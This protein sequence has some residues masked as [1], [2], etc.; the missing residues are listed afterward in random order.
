ME[1]YSNFLRDAM[2]VKPASKR[3]A[4]QKSS[5]TPDD[6]FRMN[7]NENPFGPSPIAIETLSKACKKCF[8]YPDWFSIELKKNIA[9]MYSL[10]I[11]NIVIGTGESSIICMLGEIF[12]N[13]GDE[14]IIGDPSYEGFRDVA[15]DYGAKP[16]IVPVTESLE[17][18]LDALLNAVTQKTKILVICNPN[19]PTGSYMDCA[20]L[21]AFIRKIPSHVITVIDEAYL[22]YVTVEGA[23][24]MT[25]LI[26]KNFDKALIVLKTFSKIYGMAGLRIGYSISSPEVADCLCKSNHAWNVSK[27]GQITAAAAIKDQAYIKKIRH[28]IAE[29]RVKV[30]TALRELGCKVFDSQ[31]NFILFKSPVDSL[32]VAKKLAEEKIL[33]GT[34]CGYDRVS[35]GTPEMNDKFIECMKNIL[36]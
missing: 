25:N 13:P 7:Y 24:S 17:Y 34:P 3:A 28:I 8:E 21:E 18:D 35:L 31:T 20:K 26:Q 1:D 11:S 19:N 5:A 33:I 4:R 29:E 22:E 23:Y 9:D 27:V 15:Y 2:K 14:F 30:A 36:H 16:I 6:I 10:D 12:I 32:V